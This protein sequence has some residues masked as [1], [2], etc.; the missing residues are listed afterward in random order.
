MI[1]FTRPSPMKKT[2]TM[3][4]GKES[5]RSVSFTDF[6]GNSVTVTL[7]QMCLAEL[8]M[9]AA[10]EYR[11]MTEERAKLNRFKIGDHV[12]LE[13]LGVVSEIKNM[14]GVQV[15]NRTDADGVRKATPKEIAE[16][17]KQGKQ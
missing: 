6:N 1:E 4:P 10:A 13:H 8:K 12:Y 2:C 17:K 9:K 14:E 7:C 15:A 3:H 5:V 11:S 16:Y